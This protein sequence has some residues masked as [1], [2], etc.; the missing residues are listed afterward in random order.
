MSD[1]PRFTLTQNQPAVEIAGVGLLDADHSVSLDRAAERMVEL[2]DEHG[3]PLTGPELHD[4]AGAWCKR[5]G[6]VEVAGSPAVQAEAA[7]PD[8]QP[9]PQPLPA[10]VPDNT[11]TA[12]PMAPDE[13]E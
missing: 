13:R 10:P 8:G 3:E 7:V 2:Q 11:M 12:A 5:V 4:A 9:T 1:Q 6:G